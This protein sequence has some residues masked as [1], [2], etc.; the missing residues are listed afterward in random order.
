RRRIHLSSFQNT[1]PSVP[2]P[3]RT[4]SGRSLEP[5]RPS[6]LEVSLSEVDLYHLDVLRNLRR[7]AFCNF[8]ASVHHYGPVGPGEDGPYVVLYD[9]DSYT[10]LPYLRNHTELL[11][12]FLVVEPSQRFVEHH[13]FGLDR[14]GGSNHESLLAVYVE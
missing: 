9:H 12:D 2:L 6:H 8:L 4:L 1:L 3:G 13:K 10:L 11:C 7:R 14:Q 5:A